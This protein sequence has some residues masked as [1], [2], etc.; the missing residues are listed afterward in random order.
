ML[1]PVI[2]RSSGETNTELVKEGN[3]EIKEIPL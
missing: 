2:S 3:I 1:Q